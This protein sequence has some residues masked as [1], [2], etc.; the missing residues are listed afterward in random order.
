MP[1]GVSKLVSPVV[2]VKVP[3]LAV[4]ACAIEDDAYVAYD[5]GAGLRPDRV[6][7]GVPQVL[8][9]D[10]GGLRQELPAKPVA[11]ALD[12]PSQVARVTSVQ[13]DEPGVLPVPA[14]HATQA[15]DVLAVAP[16]KE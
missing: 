9:K 14:A 7:A 16:P 15:A 1:A 13:E 4:V 10:V 8:A 2:K 6:V 3:A 12:E 5:K 11:T